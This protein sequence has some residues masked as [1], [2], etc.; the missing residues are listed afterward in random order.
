MSVERPGDGTGTSAHHPGTYSAGARVHDTV[1]A[2]G[3]GHDYTTKDVQH[4]LD[5]APQNEWGQPV[6]HRNGKPLLLENSRGDRGWIMRWDT[7]A[8]SWVA[9]NR[10]LYEHGLPAKGEPG[11]YGYDANGDLLPYANHRP[12][13]AKGQLEETWELSHEENL[14][15][16]DELDL[17]LKKPEPN[18]IWV[19]V[20]SIDARSDVVDLGMKGKWRLVEWEPGYLRKGEW[21]MGHIP[22]RR[23]VEAWD[24]YMKSGR[25]P[26][27]AKDFV[28]WFQTAENYR[29]QDPGANRADNPRLTRS[30]LGES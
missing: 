3:S 26:D 30:G 14:E 27:A 7:E 23:Y 17:D 10:G 15:L 6:D 13:Y 2:K 16:I 12:P 24:K 25:D 19:E 1:P 20:R 22:D 18:Q 29:V 4:T 8:G 5:E 11:S 9:E 28:T 21:G